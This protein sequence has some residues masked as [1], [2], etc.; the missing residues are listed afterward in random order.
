MPINL[1]PTHGSRVNPEGV[2]SFLP[3]LRTW[4]SVTPRVV[5]SRGAIFMASTLEVKPIEPEGVCD[6]A[7]TSICLQTLEG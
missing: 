6:N 3:T 4:R 7:V 2:N 1:S 5:F